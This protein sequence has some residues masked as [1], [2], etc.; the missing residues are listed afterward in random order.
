MASE[1]PYNLYF[2]VMAKEWKV[3]LHLL[4]F[5]RS[6]FRL[7]AKQSRRIWRLGSNVY[8]SCRC[9]REKI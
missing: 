1:S 8:I 4:R 5:I 2:E 6:I 3:L 7:L 9:L